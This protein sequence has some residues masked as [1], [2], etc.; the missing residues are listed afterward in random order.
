MPFLVVTPCI[1]VKIYR[2]FGG[3]LCILPHRISMD[4]FLTNC[5]ASHI[6]R[7]YLS[8]LLLREPPTLKHYKN[9]MTNIRRYLQPDLT[10]K[11]RDHR[12]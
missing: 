1:V 4:M 5:T 8:Y 11:Y 6:R 9:V 2:H 3:T 10:L 12:R 7:H